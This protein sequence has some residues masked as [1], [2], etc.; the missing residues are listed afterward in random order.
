MKLQ[1]LSLIIR[2]GIGVPVVDNGVVN[3]LVKANIRA[4]CTIFKILCKG[5]MFFAQIKKNR[6]IFLDKF[7]NLGKIDEYAQLFELFV[8]H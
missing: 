4:H 1:R 8:V 3:I 6:A 5:T 2:Q 7:V